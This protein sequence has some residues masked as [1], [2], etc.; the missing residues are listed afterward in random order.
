ME[1]PALLVIISGPSGTGKST[2]IRE[3]MRRR[4]LFFSVSCTTRPMREGE[5]DGV[6][7][8]FISRERFEQLIAED[9]LLEYAEYAGRFYGTPR[10]PAEEQMARGTDVLLDIEVQGARQVRDRMPDA[11]SVFL[12]PPSWEEL[13]RRLRNRGTDSE[14]MIRR[15]LE[16]ARGELDEARTYDYLVV[17]DEVTAAA[18]RICAILDGERCRT[19]R[20]AAFFSEI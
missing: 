15:R 2:V 19:S 18:D 12:T 1:Q 11:V 4:T 3:I 17:N 20:C 8:H 6:D 14:E 13:E 5:R 10:R 7:Y 16:T 9:A